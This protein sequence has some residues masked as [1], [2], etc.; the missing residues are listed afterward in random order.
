MR[1]VFFLCHSRYTI[2]V[3][4][5]IK[6]IYHETDFCTLIVSDC[7]EDSDIF[8]EGSNNIWDRVIILEEQNIEPL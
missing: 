2:F 8:A 5:F 4:Y 7:L 3:A 6:K 1:N